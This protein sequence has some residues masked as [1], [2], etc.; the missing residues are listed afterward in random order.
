MY[1]C[2]GIITVIGPDASS[3]Q[4]AKEQLQIS[5]KRI[6]LDEAQTNWIARDPTSLGVFPSMILPSL[7]CV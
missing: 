1:A 7:V 3:V 5:E 4:N 2:L 6:P